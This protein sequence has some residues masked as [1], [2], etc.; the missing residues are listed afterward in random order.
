MVVHPPRAEGF[1]G[2][3]GYLVI[4]SVDNRG[5]RNA[6]A[7]HFLVKSWVLL[8]RKLHEFYRVDVAAV[9]AAQAHNTLMAFCLHQWLKVKP[10]FLFHPD[11]EASAK[12]IAFMGLWAQAAELSGNYPLS[13]AMSLVDED[14]EP[15]QF[16]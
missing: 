12:T 14:I 6:R 7:I 3:V 1:A 10:Y 5:L 15:Q 16:A 9:D 2:T 8:L 13:I 11:D 4:V